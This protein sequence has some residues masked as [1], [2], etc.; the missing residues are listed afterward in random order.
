M[1]G[2][3]NI[4]QCC[5]ENIPPSSRCHRSNSPCR[6]NGGDE[7]ERDI[8]CRSVKRMTLLHL[9][10]IHEFILI[11]IVHTPRPEAEKIDD[12]QPFKD[13]HKWQPPPQ[14]PYV[15][16]KKNSRTRPLVFLPHCIFKA[17]WTCSDDVCAW[18]GSIS[19]LTT[20]SY[21]PH[22]RLHQVQR[23]PSNQ[24]YTS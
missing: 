8:K 23:P 6:P 16:Q 18:E 24:H 12:V 17:D 11:P 13:S 10:T 2:R 21:H 5:E 9:F 15:R 14:L 4:G 7:N 3:Y 19:D 20:C 22:E 1:T